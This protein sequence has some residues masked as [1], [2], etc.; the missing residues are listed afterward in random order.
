MDKRAKKWLSFTLRWGI[1]VVGVYWVLANISWSNRVL[2]VSPKTGWPVSVKL[3]GPAKQSDPQFEIIDELGKPTTVLRDYLVAKSDRQKIV[4]HRD[5]KDETL[6]VLG[7][8]VSADPDRSHWPILAAPPRNVWDR[9]WDVHNAP[10]IVIQPQNVVGPYSAVVEYPL[11]DVGIGQM[12]RGA[13]IWLLV[14]AVVIFPTAISLPAV[15]WHRLLR[16]LGVSVPLS[17]A[18]V[19]TMVGNF[20]NTFMPGSTGGD[21]L[22]AYYASKQTHEPE[23][24]TRAVVS[25]LFD[26][27]V[28]LLA[29]VILGGSMAGAAFVRAVVRGTYQVDPAARLCEKVAIASAAMLACAAFGFYVVLHPALRSKIEPLLMRLPGKKH[30][31]HILETLEIYRTRP[32][33]VLWALLITLPVHGTTIVSAMLAGMA[34]GLHIKALF[35]FVAVPVIVLVGA[36][37]ISPQGAGVMEFFAIL[38]LRPQDPIVSHAVA[39]TMSI[40]LVQI[41]WN[42]TGGIFVLKGGYHAP[43]ADEKRELE[44]IDSSRP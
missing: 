43:T 23:L 7:L 13:N 39:L 31:E 10:A 35:Y 17:R 32:G 41:F 8:K 42:L 15:R 34:F 24:K 14:I 11:I 27:V 36:I 44:E 28:G 18:F 2:V 4:V 20:Y 40:R 9:Y 1:A 38:L 6:A 21:V 29:L 3:V 30:I 22:K 26:R 25:V 5:G 37:P 16:A 12:L 19:I 33:L